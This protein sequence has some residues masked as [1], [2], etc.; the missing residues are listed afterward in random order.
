MGKTV[1]KDKT[2]HFFKWE[3]YILG[4]KLTCDYEQLCERA[5]VCNGLLEFPEVPGADKGDRILQLDGEVL[6]KEPRS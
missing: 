3:L 6:C 4:H 2:V 5:F 1:L